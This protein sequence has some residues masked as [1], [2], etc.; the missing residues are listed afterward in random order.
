MTFLLITTQMC[1][2]FLTCIVLNTV[3]NLL[4]L[5][6]VS[7]VIA[8]TAERYTAICHPMLYHAGLCGP[9][10]AILVLPLIWLASLSVPTFFNTMLAIKMREIK[11]LIICDAQNLVSFDQFYTSIKSVM[12]GCFF[13]FSVLAVVFVYFQLTWISRRASNDSGASS[14]ALMTVTLHAIHLVLLLS[15]LFY[16]PFMNWLKKLKVQNQMLLNLYFVMFFV[17]FVLPR[18]L[19][20]LVYG[21][22]DTKLRLQIKR[23]VL[24]T[25]SSCIA[26]RQ[27]Q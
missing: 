16:L 23:H 25:I 8:M 14:R 18:F 17:V 2:Y 22:R 21:L 27:C 24:W 20:P 1:M 9:R 7:F 3:S 12:Y 4:F 13:M 26:V 6:S 11:W 5:S 15:S 10:M 19:S